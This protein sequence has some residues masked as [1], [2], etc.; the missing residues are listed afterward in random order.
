LMLDVDV[1]FLKNR[2]FS[3]WFVAITGE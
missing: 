2:W 1:L 3:I